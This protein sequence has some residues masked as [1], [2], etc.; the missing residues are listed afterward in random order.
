MTVLAALIGVLGLI[1]STL[2]FG[3]V[4][5]IIAGIAWS[6]YDFGKMIYEYIFKED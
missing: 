4:M 6:L 5:V 1:L 3:I 2:I